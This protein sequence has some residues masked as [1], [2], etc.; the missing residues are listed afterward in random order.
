MFKTFYCILCKVTL[1]WRNH[2]HCCYYFLRGR[3]KKQKMKPNKTFK[4]RGEE[5]KS[6]VAF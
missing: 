5:K 1:D 6:M 2:F 4:K 3:R